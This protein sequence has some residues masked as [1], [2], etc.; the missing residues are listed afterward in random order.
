MT[1]RL[2]ALGCTT[3]FIAVLNGCVGLVSNS[4]GTQPNQGVQ[5]VNHIIFL[6]QENRSFDSYFGAMRGYWAANGIQDQQ[7]DGLAQFNP[8]ADPANAPTNPGCDPAFPFIPPSTNPYCQIDSAS[9]VV[10]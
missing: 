7:F 4:G 8:P 5:Q 1:G 6:A 9:P 3:V 2:C 10:P